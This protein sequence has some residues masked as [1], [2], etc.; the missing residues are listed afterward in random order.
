MATEKRI[1][2]IKMMIISYLTK[3]YG[4]VSLEIVR[5]IFLLQKCRGGF[6]D[7]QVSRGGPCHWMICEGSR[8][9]PCARSLCRM[10]SL[11]R[12]RWSPPC[13]PSSR[14]CWGRWWCWSG[15]PSACSSRP[16][17]QGWC[18]TSH[19]GSGTQSGANRQPVERLEHVSSANQRAA[20]DLWPMRGQHYS[21][22]LLTRQQP[23][24]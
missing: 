1:I 23:D 13:S 14:D 7:F 6:T 16:S 20:S 10:M 2:S 5:L 9:T 17:C 24:M 3:T 21:A 22:T 19:P 11:R 12:P 4:M 15:T 18:C 8:W